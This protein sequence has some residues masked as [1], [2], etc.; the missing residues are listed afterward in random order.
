MQ[1]HLKR[2]SL[3]ILTCFLPFAAAAQSTPPVSQ[4]DSVVVTASRTPQPLKDVV[5]DVSVI[6]SEEL[7]KAG[8]SSLVDVLSKQPG[9]RL[10]NSGGPQT[11]TSV[12]LRGANS[13]HTLVLIDGIR[14]NGA[15][16]G[17]VQ[18]PA[19]D[20]A[21]IERVE[22]LRGAASSLYGSDAIGG[23]INIITKKS[24]EDRPFAAWGNV[25]I[26][27]YDTFKSSVG[28][29]GAADDWD[30]SLAS[31]MAESSGFN[32]TNPDAGFLYDPDTDGYSQHALSGSL[33]YRWRPGQ[34]IRL[35]AYNGYI[36]GDYDS[37]PSMTP[38]H[39]ISRQQAYTLTSTNE[40]TDTW[41]SVLRLGF[42][43]ESYDNRG[44]YGD[45]LSQTI[46]RS[47][48][49][50]N[51]IQLA[52]NHKVSALL[53]RIEERL[54]STNEFAEDQR[55]TNAVGLIYRGDFGPAHLQASARNDNISGYGNKKTGSLA[56]DFDLTS[57]WQIGVA[58]STGFKAPTFES[59]YTPDGWGTPNPNLRP[60]QSRN[61]E[62]SLKYHDDT[63]LAGIT[64]YQNKIKDLIVY[65]FAGSYNEDKATIRGVTLT[66]SQE[67]GNT[68]LRASA[69]FMN[70]RND[71]NGKQ[72]ARR[73]R[74]VYNVGVDHR[75]G[76]WTLG[77][78][79]QFT[80]KRYDDS[81]NT[82]SRK[83]GGHSLLNLTAGYELTK[84]VG[85]QVRWN[86]V[87]DKDYSNT[88]GYNTQGSNVFVNLSWRM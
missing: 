70:P 73:A 47:Y 82:E 79:Y 12:F 30:Y 19:I 61:I 6:S 83:L 23:V 54:H 38:V 64:V 21:T 74:Q 66:A 3:A 51:N 37:G 44:S 69:D 72:L 81:N 87:L 88:Y 59:L 60:E 35:T 63:T 57:N 13:N 48:L 27:S 77:A 39:G 50:Q 76:F 26:G 86:N 1:K 20:P 78:E 15:V 32:A 28:F 5:G 75:V 45:S 55:N 34:H 84:N 49:W 62:A 14:V 22:I 17:G 11:L 8:Q 42:S 41:E 56:L 33:G 67:Y 46:Q 80:G 18:W 85:V 4:L 58:G 52:E 25:G 9:V 65:D 36:D 68:T 16:S 10:T 43:K 24:G 31:S 29:S 7:Q 71:T 2:H 40:I 53:E